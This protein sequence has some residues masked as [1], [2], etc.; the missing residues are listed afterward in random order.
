M[1]SSMARSVM[2]AKSS[3]SPT[4][5]RTMSE[6]ETALARR[7]GPSA[8]ASTSSD[9]ALRR[10]RVA[11]WSR[12]NRFSSWSGSSSLA[13]RRSMNSIWRSRSDWLRRARF[14][15]MSLMPLRSVRDCSAATSIAACSTAPKA[16][17]SSANSSCDLTSMF[18]GRIVTSAL[19]ECIESTSRG[20]CSV[21][22]VFAASVRRRRLEVIDRVTVAARKRARSRAV[23]EPPRNS[24]TSRLSDWT[25]AEAMAISLAC[26]RCSA[27]CSAVS[28]P[29]LWSSQSFMGVVRPTR[30]SIE[31]SSVYVACDAA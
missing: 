1:S 5:T 24:R 31:P 29:M 15:K 20:S 17:A 4:A 23:A 9:S 3:T 21:E 25:C 2:R 27:V 30:G 6:T 22:I 18:V 19:G 7:R 16:V 13:S 12:R 8:W 26:N 11:R 14:T 28:R 10:M